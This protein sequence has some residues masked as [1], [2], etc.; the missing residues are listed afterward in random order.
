MS[1]I[2]L[3]SV[4]TLIKQGL[5]TSEAL[6]N[7]AVNET[8]KAAIE[9]RRTVAQM[10]EDEDEDAAIRWL[11]DARWRSTGKAQ[12]RGTELHAAAEALAL[13]ARPIVDAGVMPYVEQYRKWLVTYSPRFLMAEAPVYNPAAY[14]AGT[15][16]GVIEFGGKPFL[17]DIKTTP[18]GPNS[19]KRRPPYPEVALQL[20]AYAHATDVGVISE[21]RYA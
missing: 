4:T 19:D 21:Q 7:W 15:L 1:E 11:R 3:W 2:R 8:A 16:D 18:H 5:G 9:K 20:C 12:V 6:V 10:L 14:Y 17:F 13:G